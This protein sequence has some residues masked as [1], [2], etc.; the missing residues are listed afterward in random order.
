M[1][2]KILK[3]TTFIAIASAIV[4]AVLGIVSQFYPPIQSRIEWYVSILLLIFAAML[5]YLYS[6]IE[7]IEN[8]TDLIVRKLGVQ[9]IEVFRTRDELFSRMTDISIGSQ[10][11]STLMFSDPPDVIGGQ[12][13]NYFKKVG[14][15]IR[16]TPTMIFRRISTLGD[17]RKIK[18]ILEI[19]NEMFETHNFSLAYINIDHKNTPL[20]CAHII[21]KNKEFYTFVF[22]TVPASGNVCAFLIRNNEVGR[23][24]LDYFNGLWE[25][26]PKLM[27]GKQINM[28]EVEELA[29]GF[30]IEDSKEYVKFKEKVEKSAL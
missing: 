1:S 5:T 18:W 27:E 19:L 11:I 14:I 4:M 17:N 12:M 22:H 16:K 8:R 15:Y 2:S 29:K 9:A 13:E 24:A 7:L 30:C 23:V 6:R 28:K 21:E 10:A 20:L 25:K 3:L 26:S